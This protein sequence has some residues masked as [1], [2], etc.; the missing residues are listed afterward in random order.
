LPPSASAIGSSNL[1]LQL[2]ERSDISSPR[3]IQSEA[4]VLGY[5][6]ISE[7]IWSGVQA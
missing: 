7:A 1:W 4:A 3:N 2:D 6:R 5:A